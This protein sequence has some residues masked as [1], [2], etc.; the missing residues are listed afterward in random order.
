MSRSSA[1][2][3]LVSVCITSYNYGRYLRDAIES[4]LNQTY[5]YIEVI[6]SDNGSTDNTHDVLADY[7]DDPRVRTFINETNVGLCKNHNLAIQ[8]STGEYIVVLSADDVMFPY[9]VDRLMQRMHDPLDPVRIVTAQGMELDEHLQPLGPLLTLG[10]LPFAYS[11]RDDLGP[12]LLN[13]HHVYPAKLIARSVYDQVGLFNESLITSIDIELCARFEA[14]DIPSA[15]LPEFVCGLRRHSGRRS[16]KTTGLT[17]ELIHDKLCMLERGLDPDQTWRLEGLEASIMAIFD[18]SLDR[19][20]QIGAEPLD[21]AIAERLDRA[22]AQCAELAQRTPAWPAHEPE[23]SVIILSEG[24]IALLKVTLDAVI[25]QGVGRLE[26]MVVQTSGCDVQPYISSL[27]Y[28]HCVRIIQVRACEKPRHAYRYALDVARGEFVTYLNEGQRI[29]PGL[30]T[31]VLGYARSSNAEVL[32]LPKERIDEYFTLLTPREQRYH[33]FDAPAVR[34]Q[35]RM[36]GGP[37]AL[38]QLVHRRR[39]IPPSTI[40]SPTFYELMISE[41]ESYFV[42]ILAAAKRTVAFAAGE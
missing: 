8:R 35:A 4:A 28:A 17:N 40:F 25:A 18:M 20:A 21:P 37:Y 24:Y 10:N 13:F 9:H 33:Q 12:Q 32:L 5:P 31:T 6:V 42:S 19:L 3:A 34:A 22:R 38:C 26:I 2:Q 29:G 23:L 16:I 27:P 36:D 14:A 1:A 30:Y 15:F 41:E 39:A 7:K 11:K